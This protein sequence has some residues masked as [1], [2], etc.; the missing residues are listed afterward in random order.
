MSSQNT[1]YIAEPIF[2]EKLQKY[3]TELS[4]PPIKKIGITTNH[5]ERRERELLGTISP[6]KISIVKA[7][8]D[9]N[10]KAIESMLHNILDN[11]RLDGEYFW[12][13][14]ETLVD[15]VSDFIVNYHP[16]AKEIFIDDDSDVKA[17]ADAAKKKSSQRIYSE[18]VPELEELGIDC[19]VTKN[20]KGVILNMDEYRLRINAKTGGRYTLTIWSN[21]KTTEDALKDFIGSQELSAHGSEESPRRARI[22]MAKL[23]TIIES[24][25][26]YT[27]AE[28]TKGNENIDNLSHSDHT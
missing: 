14:N 13:G 19:K 23:E 15:A 24:L 22:P 12:D 18:V 5:P 4:F 25:K 9:V 2:S 27:K 8:T 6:I 21:S 3:D 26:Q 10:A 1:L 11:T 7:W 16:E 28:L 17:A 20:E